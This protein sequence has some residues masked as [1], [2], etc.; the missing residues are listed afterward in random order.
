MSAFRQ[1]SILHSLLSDILSGVVA[2][3]QRLP[4]RSE[5]IARFNASSVTV[6][7]VLDI[8]I[9]DGF[10]EPRGRSGT[11]IVDHPPHLCHY[12][13]VIA[14]TLAERAHWP[15]FWNALAGEARHLFAAGP[16]T[17]SVYY[18]IASRDERHY[19]TLLHDVQAR[20]LTGLVFASNPYWLIN[21]PILDQP[22]IARVSIGD[23]TGSTLAS[24]VRLENEHFISLAIERLAIHGRKRVALLTVPGIAHR[25]REQF[26]SELRAHGLETRQEWQQAAVIDYPEWAEHI[27]RL[28]FRSSS[29]A[30]PD[31]LII[32][33]DNLVGPATAGMRAVGLRCPEDVDV[34][35]HANFPAT[36]AS[37]LPITRLG[38]DARALLQLC[39][40]DLDRQRLAP[41]RPTLSAL[42]PVFSPDPARIAEPLP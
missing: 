18:G 15:N 21:T 27:M 25:Q 14:G 28:L 1:Q 23:R 33:D 20:R 38:Y 31:A 22:G 4:T 29:E 12:G 5:L 39:V 32:A 35:A 37:A 24:V 11:F 40:A 17:M 42:A 16:R 9:A 41:E 26:Q 34:I 30:L 8:L 19:P 6:Q 2:P 7:R 10:V 36:T 13:L 3:S